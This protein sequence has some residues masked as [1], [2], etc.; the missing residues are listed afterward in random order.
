MVSAQA[1]AAVQVCRPCLFW[2]F[3]LP[4]S[5]CKKRFPSGLLVESTT[6]I[7]ALQIG[8]RVHFAFGEGQFWVTALVVPGQVGP[9]S[10]DSVLRCDELDPDIKGQVLVHK[11]C[12]NAPRFLQVGHLICVPLPSLSRLR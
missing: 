2:R 4:L 3:R 12:A 7:A 6:N 8:V 9:Y 5:W 1:Q 10:S 11:M